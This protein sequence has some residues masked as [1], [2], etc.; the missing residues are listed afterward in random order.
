MAYVAAEGGLAGAI[1]DRAATNDDVVHAT[2]RPGR[3]AKIAP[4][5]PRET[6]LRSTN[7]A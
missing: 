2:P 4:S 3:A 1:D 5:S 7:I 6:D